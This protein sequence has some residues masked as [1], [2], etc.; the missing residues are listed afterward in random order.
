MKRGL[1]LLSVVGLA[2]AGVANA[3]VQQGDTEL[4][5]L[6]GF[7]TVNGHNGGDLDNL[8]VESRLGYFLTDNVQVGGLVAA[9]WTQEEVTGGDN[10]TTAYSLGGFANYHFM[11]TNQWVPYVGGRIAWTYAETDPA[12]GDDDKFDGLEY[13]PVAGLRFEL[14]AY[15]DFFAEYRYTLFSGD[16]KDLY[17]DS[18]GLFLGIIH[19]FK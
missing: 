16:F 4:D 15:N 12:V 18:H 2:L 17:D 5:L 1:M 11:P 13:G 9:D 14:N 19:Q 6:G 3:S 7:E 10:E 8:F